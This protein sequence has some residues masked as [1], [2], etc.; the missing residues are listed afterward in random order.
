MGGRIALLKPGE[1]AN[2]VCTFVLYRA[3]C[4]VDGRCLYLLHGGFADYKT[5]ALFIVWIFHIL[6]IAIHIS[7][8]RL[9]LKTLER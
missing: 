6:A 9:L 7:T 8:F 3:N 2:D 1:Q 5:G 4:L